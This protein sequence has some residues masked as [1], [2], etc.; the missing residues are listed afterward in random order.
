MRMNPF[1]AYSKLPMSFRNMYQRGGGGRGN[2]MVAIA[3]AMTGLLV[4]NIWSVLLVV[5]IVTHTSLVGKHYIE[6]GPYALLLVVV[7]AFE[8][9]SIN[10]VFRRADSD[11]TFAHQVR[12]TSPMV[13]KCMP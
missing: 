3:C 6:A 9:L 2:F 5:V 1:V 11:P 8:I 10:S 12:S 4:L 7:F 13:S